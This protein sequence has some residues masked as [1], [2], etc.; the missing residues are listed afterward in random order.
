[1]TEWALITRLVLFVFVLFIAFMALGALWDWLT[2]KFRERR[3]SA[4]P[5]NV[6]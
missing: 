1:M 3:G 6:G 4:M 2:W 5:P